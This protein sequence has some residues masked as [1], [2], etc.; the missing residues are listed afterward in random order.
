MATTLT[1][2]YRLFKPFLTGVEDLASVL[3]E[4]ECLGDASLGES[5]SSMLLSLCRCPPQVC[6]VGLAA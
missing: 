4:V 3:G 2:I 5:I 6:L 1:M